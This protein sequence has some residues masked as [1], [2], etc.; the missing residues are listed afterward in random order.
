MG[1][2]GK[3][4]DLQPDQHNANKGTPRGASLLE[5]SLR[6]YGAGRSIL[7]DR[8]GTIIAGNKTHQQAVDAQLGM[9]LVETDGHELVVVMRKD[10]DL[11]A[12]P[13]ARELAYADN[14]IAQVDLEWDPAV[15][16]ADL[17][18]GVELGKMFTGEELSELLQAAA[19]EVLTSADAEQNVQTKYF[20]MIECASE[21]DQLA[22]LDR[23]MK[24]GL[25][26]K[27]VIG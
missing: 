1:K 3:L 26:V 7:V 4:T 6:K 18:A 27:A 25:Q 19:D 13:K 9:R 11:N 5:D 16:A 8:N 10:L 12:D 23:L 22:M 17:E 15:V 21:P 24:E 20:V 14:R 2:P